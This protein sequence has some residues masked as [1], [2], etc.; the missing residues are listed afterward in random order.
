MCKHR[1]I[2]TKG[3]MYTCTTYNVNKI[4][5]RYRENITTAQENG[6]YKKQPQ[7]LTSLLF[8][9]RSC[10][11]LI[12]SISSFRARYSLWACG[13]VAGGGATTEVATILSIQKNS[14]VI[15]TCMHIS[16]FFQNMH[17][18]VLHPESPSLFS[19]PR[20]S[21]Q[22]QPQTS[23]D[24]PPPSAPSANEVCGKCAI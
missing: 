21:G 4:T 23:V 5:Q 13:G 8:L 9:R 18:C 10:S 19:P 3:V 12:L 7:V 17:T 6:M 14:N 1:L 22:T 15:N 11:F 16:K 20:S 24:A 2:S